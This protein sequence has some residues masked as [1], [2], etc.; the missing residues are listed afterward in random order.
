MLVTAVEKRKGEGYAVFVE[1]EYALMLNEETLLTEKI[2]AGVEV[3]PQRLDELQKKAE[4]RRTRERALYLL[5][6][7]S[8]AKEELT[9]KLARTSCRETAETVAARMEELGLLNDED[10]ARRFADHLWRFKG[11]GAGR[12]RQEMSRKGLDRELISRE[13]ERLGEENTEEDV[14]QK[15]CALID[16]KYL[17]F[18]DDPK[19]RNK[20][21]QALQR[22]G[23]AYEDIR[24]A[25]QYYDH[26]EEEDYAD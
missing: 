12:I 25:L 5:E 7:K 2:R 6:K 13:L 17:R 1:G 4:L 9:Q 22:L 14:A 16:R 10:Y 3:T 8:Y 26:S 20:T 23:Y 15:L 19:G 11:Y 18:L 24:R 21:I